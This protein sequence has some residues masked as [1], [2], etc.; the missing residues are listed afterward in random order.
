MRHLVG[1]T[2]PELEHLRP[3]EALWQPKRQRK[4]FGVIRVIKDHPSPSS[5]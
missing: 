4:I 1:E 2:T 5:V 3:D